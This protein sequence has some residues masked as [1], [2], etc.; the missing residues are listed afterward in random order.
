MISEKEMMHGFDY[1]REDVAGWLMSEKLNGCRAYWDGTQMWSRGGRV[2]DIPGEMRSLLPAYALD[3][4]IHAGRGGFETSRQAVQY[5]RWTPACE[6]S[7]FDAPDRNSI[8]SLRY[9]LLRFTLPLSGPVNFVPQVKIAGIDE[10]VSNLVKVQGL[11]GEAH[12]T[13]S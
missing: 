9:D 12:A 1:N 13:R 11:G 8:F 4:E 6:F 3:G 2:I 7:A 5:G 10:A